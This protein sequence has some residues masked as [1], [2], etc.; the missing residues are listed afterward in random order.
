M[1]LDAYNIQIGPENQKLW[2]KSCAPHQDLSF[3]TTCRLR[4]Q[5]SKMGGPR[6]PLA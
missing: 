4:I 1:V 2:N 6:Q 5:F 3:D